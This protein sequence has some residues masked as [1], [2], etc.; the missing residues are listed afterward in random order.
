MRLLGG[1]AGGRRHGGNSDYGA[2]DVV[3]TM[4]VGTIVS[5]VVIIV[6]VM[7][8]AKVTVEDRGPSSGLN[9]LRQ[10]RHPFS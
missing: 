1:Y 4:M 5:V 2:G 6:T 7:M 10:E 3:V 8:T 9:K